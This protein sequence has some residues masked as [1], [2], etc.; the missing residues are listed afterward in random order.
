MNQN[1][2]KKNV[3]KA[4]VAPKKA[5]SKW[6]PGMPFQTINYILM[7]AGIA[8]LFVGYLLLAGG[9]SDDPTQFSDAI[10]N[11][12]RLRVA[13]I[14]L[15]IGFVIELFAIM[16]RPC[17]RCAKKEDGEETPENQNN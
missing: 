14:T 10:F 2:Q 1:T 17:A 4:P 6:A 12:R 11:T 15:V 9:G 8:V 16:Y 7:L 5:E 3:R 13:P